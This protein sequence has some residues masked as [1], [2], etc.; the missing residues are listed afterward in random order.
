MNKAKKK[1]SYPVI[2][3][4]A[5]EGGFIAYVPALS[6]CHTQGDTFEESEQNINEA[7]ELYLE[8]LKI[9]NLP[10]PLPRN[11][12]QGRIEIAV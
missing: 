10:I 4:A 3:E 7:I 12:Y 9:N 11:I 6:G 8:T 1:I 5:E 2:Y